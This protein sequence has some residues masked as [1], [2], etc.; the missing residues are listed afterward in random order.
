MRVTWYFDFVSPFAYLQ[1]RQLRTWPVTPV[2]L[3][4]IVLARVLDAH[5]HLAPAEIPAKRDFT[6]RHV[7]W[8]ADR[9]GVPL[10][11]PDAGH[12]FNSLPL[13]R[14]ATAAGGDPAVIERLFRYV[15]VDG[16]LP[17]QEE[18]WR[19][20]LDELDLGSGDVPETVTAQLRSETERAIAAGVF[21]VPTACVGGRVFWGLA[22][23]GM[24]EE[25]LRD[26][27]AFAAQ[28]YGTAP[29]VPVAARRVR[30]IQ[31]AGT[32]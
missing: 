9:A 8:L 18:P 13:L 19:A 21:G 6:Y 32:P 20:L 23:T 11:F 2:E 3:R 5:G 27:D 16:C 17:Q 28:S 29:A 25:Y 7:L 4:P 26:P 30:T 22:S 1:F 12:P 10:R 31:V 14:I 15:W 24:L